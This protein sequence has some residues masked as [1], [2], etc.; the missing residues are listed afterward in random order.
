MNPLSRVTV[1]SFIS[2]VRSYPY[3]AAVD[4]HSPFSEE[5]VYFP[6]LIAIQHTVVMNVI[7]QINVIVEL[8]LEAFKLL[9]FIT[10]CRERLKFTLL[11]AVKKFSSADT[12]TLHCTGVE[13]NHLRWCP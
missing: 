3:I 13:L 9:E 12:G 5:Y 7:T 1:F 6:P 8:H 4:L 11:N 10:I 2:E